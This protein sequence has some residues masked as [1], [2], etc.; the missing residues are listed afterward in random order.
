MKKVLRNSFALTLLMFLFSIPYIY[1]FYYV[2]LARMTVV[3][4]ATEAEVYMIGFLQLLGLVVL[5]ISVSSLIGFTGSEKLGFKGWGDWQLIKE[6]LQK[7]LLFGIIIALVTYLFRDYHLLNEFRSYYPSS[8][9]LLSGT[10]LYISI[11]KELCARFGLVT[12]LAGVFKTEQLAIILAAIIFAIAQIAVYQLIGILTQ[13]DWLLLTVLI[14]EL[15]VSI[16]LGYLYL[17]KGL[18]MSVAVSFVANLRLMLL[19]FV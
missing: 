10:P 11:F 9:I 16:F 3:S 15:I 5:V 12:L 4:F 1:Y 8:V 6:S 19:F 2:Y 7:I 14:G 17:K 18:G 13:F